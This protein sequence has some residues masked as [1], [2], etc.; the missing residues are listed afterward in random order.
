MECDAPWQPVQL[1][2]ITVLYTL[3]NVGDRTAASVPLSAPPE[4]LLDELE[5]LDA[6]DE[7]VLLP[8]DEL[9]LLD[10]LELEL[11]ASSEQ[12]ETTATAAA[13]V[14]RTRESRESEALSSVMGHP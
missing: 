12:A 4:E 14:M 6:P 7:L 1:P 3:V 13:P 9:E 2:L 11:L 5:L 10:E 8:P